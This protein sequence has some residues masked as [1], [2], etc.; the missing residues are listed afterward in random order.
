VLFRSDGPGND[1]KY[2]A[3]LVAGNE[4]INSVKEIGVG[5][6]PATTEEQMGNQVAKIVGYGYPSYGYF[7]EVLLVAYHEASYRRAHDLVK[8]PTQSSAPFPP[9]SYAYPLSFNTVYGND[10]QADNGDVTQAINN[11]VGVVAFRGH[12][13]YGSFLTWNTTGQSYT[14]TEVSSLT[15]TAYP[16]VW[17]FTCSNGALSYDGSLFGE[18]WMNEAGKGAAA[19]YAA[20]DLSG[21][22]QNDWMD[23]LMFKHV[24]HHKQA[25]HSTAVDMMEMDLH[26]I[27][28]LP[29]TS[30]IWVYSLF[31][32]P[33]MSVRHDSRQ[34]DAHINVLACP[35][36]VC[37]IL[38]RAVW[39]DTGDPIPE[40]LISL[41]MERATGHTPVSKYANAE[42]EAVFTVETDEP[43]TLHYGVR[44]LE[45]HVGT[46]SMPIEQLQ[47]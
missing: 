44:D 6:L 36:T 8:D 38:F 4:V 22:N 42:G 46:F 25:V 39:A 2:Q 45:G 23:I 32:D 37:D 31:G 24:F 28:R 17:S 21:K 20:N 27:S 41:W 14:T 16:V 19:V 47:Q 35:G 11:G 13:S 43:G 18:E 29:S 33:H 40:A 1:T 9:F 34:I 5:R 7:D 10:P 30:N 12:G 15:N 26:N 3:K